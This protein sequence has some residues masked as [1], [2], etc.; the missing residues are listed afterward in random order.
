MVKDKR[1]YRRRFISLNVAYD[2]SPEQRW[3]ESTTRDIGAGGICL[4]TTSPIEVGKV[5]DIKFHI[6]D[7]QKPVKVSGKIVW[8]EEY[9]EGGGGKFYN[10]IQFIRIDEADRDLIGKYV[11]SATFL[12]K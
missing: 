9:K 6:P 11:D 12:R 5:V 8:N 1:R 7:E 4:I 3:L 10:G 2:M